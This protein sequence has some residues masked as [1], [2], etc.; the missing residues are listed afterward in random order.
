MYFSK[1]HRVGGDAQ[2]MLL[3]QN[4]VSER[5]NAFLAIDNVF[6]FYMYSPCLFL[7]SFA[8]LLYHFVFGDRK[9]CFVD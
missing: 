5:K 6:A 1:S 3:K 9:R 2:P 4:Y 7:R 8:F